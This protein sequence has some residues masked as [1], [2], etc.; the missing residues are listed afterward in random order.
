[1]NFRTFADLN[2]VIF[3]HI[4]ELPKDIDLVV[5]IPRSGLLAANIIALY[6][7]LP[8]TDISSLAEGKIYP[9]GR[10]RQKQE[11]VNNIS[12]ARKILVVDD[13]S[14]T[15]KS[16][17]EA[18]EKLSSTDFYSKIIFM[19]VYVCEASRK[20]PDIYF[21]TVEMPRMF[22]WNYIH[23]SALKNSCFD[24][25]GVLCPDPTEE[26]NDDG[27]KYI[28]FIRNVPARFVPTF[29][30]GYLITSRLEKY[31]A[32]T[33]YWLHKNNI[34]YRQLIM[35]NFATK[36]ERIKSGSHASFKAEHYRAAKKSDIFIESSERQAEEIARLSGKTV[37]C[38]ETHQVYTENTFRRAKKAVRRKVLKYIPK[39]LKNLIK[40]LL[41][42]N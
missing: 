18:R 10:T 2:A 39:R 34:R 41:R 21:E 1:M 20:V 40:R 32:D 36:E 7:N 16:I 25:D 26:Q 15:G 3:S 5:G 28:D 22:E 42:R 23:H 33:E 8:L 31:R 19:T 4:H 24:I 35:M 6:L 29:E 11:W 38:T 27:E 13:S 17:Q 14:G 37:F 9:T 12:Q 30:I